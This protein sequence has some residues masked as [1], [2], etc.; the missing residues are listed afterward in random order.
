MRKLLSTAALLSLTAAC[1]PDDLYRV[2]PGIDV[3]PTTGWKL[4]AGTTVPP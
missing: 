1:G 3:G 4:D 2:E